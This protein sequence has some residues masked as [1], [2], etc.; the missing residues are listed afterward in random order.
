MDETN[1]LIALL[2]GINILSL[3]GL[4]YWFYTELQALRHLTYTVQSYQKDI[5]KS[6]PLWREELRSK[7][8]ILSTVDSEQHDAIAK[9]REELDIMQGVLVEVGDELDDAVEQ[10]I[11]RGLAEAT[12]KPKRGRPRKNPPVEPPFIRQAVLSAGKQ[13]IIENAHKFRRGI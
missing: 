11:R 1:L 7:T 10:A 13:T 8:L 5:T 3:C 4:G 2:G 12:K 9:L 6:L